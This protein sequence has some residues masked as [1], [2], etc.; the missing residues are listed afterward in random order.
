MTSTHDRPIL[1][2]LT[3]TTLSLSAIQGPAPSLPYSEPPSEPHRD[4]ISKAHLQ[5]AVVEPLRIRPINPED[6]PPLV[7]FK[8]MTPFGPKQTRSMLLKPKIAHAA[9][10]GRKVFK[11]VQAVEM[12]NGQILNEARWRE[13][14]VYSHAPAAILLKP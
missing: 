6:S 4:S 10:F 7:T 1:Q 9:P 11:S 3:H 14:Q 5:A 2:N 12:I 8:P 13:P